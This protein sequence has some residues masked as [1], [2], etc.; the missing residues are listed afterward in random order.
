[1]RREGIQYL[2]FGWCNWRK[3]AAFAKPVV[4]IFL[5]QKHQTKPLPLPWPGYLVAVVALI[6]ALCG[7]RGVYVI[8]RNYICHTRISHAQKATTAAQWMS[9]Q[10][11]SMCPHTHSHTHTHPR[12]Y[13]DLCT[14][15]LTH[16]HTHSACARSLGRKKISL[17]PR[18]NCSAAN[19]TV[20]V[21]AGVNVGVAN[22]SLLH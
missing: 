16:T 15:P 12:Q 1:M 7:V 18:H 19:S 9:I 5:I 8:Q 21:D 3:A 6:N 17:E 22:C 11:R 10:K 2:Q 14:H 13:L 4:G 20:A